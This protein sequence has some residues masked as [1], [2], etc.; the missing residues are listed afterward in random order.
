M[1]TLHLS[2]LLQ[3]RIEFVCD[4]QFSNRSLRGNYLG[5]IFHGKNIIHSLA[6]DIKRPCVHYSTFA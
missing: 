6:R 3:S 1:Q 2:G 5:I 4:Y